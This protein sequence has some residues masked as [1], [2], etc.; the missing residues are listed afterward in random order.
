ATGHGHTGTLNSGVTRTTT[1]KTGGAL[2]FNGT[3]G[4]VT[5]PDADDLDLTTGMTLEA[6]VNPTANTGWRTA[7]MKEFGSD[8]AYAL[9]AGG[10]TPPLATIT[11]AGV[12]GYGEA[13]GPSGS[14]PATNAWTHLAA[15]Y[16][17]TTRTLYQHDRP[18]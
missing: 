7:I 18:S 3:S 9:Y 8:L 10:S 11:T 2:K 5:I 6:W 16:D 4:M 15:T 13:H 17:R 1:G 12:A 14:Q